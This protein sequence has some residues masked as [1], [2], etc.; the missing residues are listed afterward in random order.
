[1]E[2]TFEDT[3]YAF[4]I[5]A[6]TRSE[7]AYIYRQTEMT[8]GALLRGLADLHP[9]ALDALFWLMLK[10]NGTV[11]D[12]HKLPDYPVIKFGEALGE[13]MEAEQE[14]KEEGPT[15]ADQTAA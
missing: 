3:T 6:M 5:E 7:A 9:V 10:Q 4:D 15:T 14:S 12:I 11:R 2:I 1:M 8:V 13:A